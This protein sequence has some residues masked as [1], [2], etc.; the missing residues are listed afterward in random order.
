MNNLIQIHTQGKQPWQVKEEYK[1]INRCNFDVQIVGTGPET[2]ELRGMFKDFVESPD[3]LFY[4][5][6]VGNDKSFKIGSLELDYIREES[7]SAYRNERSTELALSKWFAEK[8]HNNIFEI[9]DVS[10]HYSFFKE[11]PVLDPF[12]PYPLAIKKDVMDYN[13]KDLNVII[14]STL[15]HMNSKEY[16]NNSDDLCIKALDKIRAESES[17]IATVPMGANNLLTE[18]IRSG[19]GGDFTF[20]VRDNTRGETNNW[21]Q[22]N[23][24]S[25]FELPYG[26]FS[27]ELDF[28]GSALAVLVLSNEKELFN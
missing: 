11:W 22:S 10:C 28:Y 19:K 1:R 25:N 5:K 14:L 7:N 15:E 13:Y 4:P 26:H 3:C 18:Y 17:Y 8:Y 12:G 27:F 9:G 24:D 16:S 23:D 21:H 6:V 2:A 20:L